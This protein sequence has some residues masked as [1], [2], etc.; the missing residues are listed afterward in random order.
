MSRPLPQQVSLPW[1]SLPRYSFV[2]SS[3]LLKLF[4]RDPGWSSGGE[5]T[6]NEERL[7]LSD[8]V[9][10]S[11]FI[12]EGHFGRHLRRMREVCRTVGGSAGRSVL[13]ACWATGNLARR[14][15]L[16]NGGLVVRR[17]R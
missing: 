4:S 12:T 1:G 10:L 8:Q 15:G 13:E 9:V 16:A 11:E 5:H 6:T 7:L 3:D 2:M 14:R 17:T